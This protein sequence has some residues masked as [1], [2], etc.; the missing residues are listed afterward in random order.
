MFFSAAR[1]AARAEIADEN[2]L[3]GRPLLGRHLAGEAMDLP[4]AE[5]NDVVE[6]LPEQRRE[7][8]LAAGD[9]GDAELAGPTGPA[10]C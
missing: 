4:P 9:A 2:R 1:S 8:R 6:R 7:F 10:R 3:A 5:R